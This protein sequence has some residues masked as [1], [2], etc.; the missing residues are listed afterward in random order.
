MPQ[1]S[2]TM[3][4]KIMKGIAKVPGDTL[5]A[6]QGLD[7]INLLD[8]MG[9][10]CDEYQ[11]RIP[12][13]KSSAVYADS[14]L[15]DGRQLISGANGN[16]TETLRLTLNGGTIIQLAALLSKLGRFKQ[17]CNDFW[18]T[19]VQI[20]PI[21]LK[22]QIV[23]E[24]GPRYALLYDIDV[25]VEDPTNPSDPS[26]TVTLNIERE[27]YWRG[28]APGD[29]PKHWSILVNNQSWNPTSAHLLQGN[30]ALHQAT[31]TNRA[32]QNAAASSYVT[33]NFIDIP[34]SKIPGDAPALL[35]VSVQQAVS[36]STTALLMGKSTKPTTGNTSRNTSTN[37][38]TVYS[39]NAADGSAQ[40][41]TSLA[42]D[43]GV[44]MSHNGNRNRS[45]TTFATATMATRLLWNTSNH[46]NGF[47]SS[48]LRGRYGVFLRARVSAAATC[49]IQLSITANSGGDTLTT[50]PVTLTDLGV[51][52]TGNST[53]W[54][55]LYLGYVG[56]PVSNKRTSVGPDGKGIWIDTA[57]VDDLALNIQAS[58]TSGAGN[59]YMSDMIFIPMD[60]GMIEM[61][62]AI[63][64]GSGSTV[65]YSW[66]YDNTG[67]FMHGTPG[68]YATIDFYSTATPGHNMEADIPEFS[69]SPIYLTPKVQNRLVFLMYVKSTNRSIYNDP[70]ASTVRVNIVPRWIGYRD[71]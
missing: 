44:P 43:T 2:G 5:S 14:P 7:E 55:L 57:Q 9:F 21:Y 15:T 22:H 17:D 10:S 4:L 45:V 20:E 8:P 61:V 25:D 18:D 60:E 46:P 58:R 48:V 28:L 39:F 34:A 30:D 49:N 41:D 12:A 42:A 51:G 24:P 26:R 32:E 36:V 65:L 66:H 69:G 71:V 27:S 64:V 40:I 50:T 37:Q 1:I 29:N 56:I 13:L 59:L 33:Q 62:S 16:V 11:M 54:A 52:G 63:A 35:N 38:M 68:E 70:S 6:E 67:Y 47:S 23:G 19:L 3:H 53:D 31:I